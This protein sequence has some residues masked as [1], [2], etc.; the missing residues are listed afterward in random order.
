MRRVLSHAGQG[1]AKILWNAIP[2]RARGRLY[3][4]MVWDG[5]EKLFGRDGA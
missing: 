4:S 3:A 1:F 2:S 5:W